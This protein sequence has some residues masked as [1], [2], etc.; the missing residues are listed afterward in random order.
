MGITGSEIELVEI[1]TKEQIKKLKT[2]FQLRFPHLIMRVINV[3][4]W[5]GEE[6]LAC[7][8]TAFYE[9]ELEESDVKAAILG[10]YYEWLNYVW[11]FK[12]NNIEYEEGKGH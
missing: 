5:L 8:F 1:K 2:A 12:R 6:K 10:E 7:W 9:I 4:M 3:F 11:A